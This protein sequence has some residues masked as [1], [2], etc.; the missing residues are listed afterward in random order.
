VDQP[1]KTLNITS[2][3][4]DKGSLN[5]KHFLITCSLA[6][7]QTDLPIVNTKALLNSSADASFINLSIAHLFPLVL[8][9]QPRRVRLASSKLHDTSI[10]HVARVHLSIGHY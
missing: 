10:T 5:S 4:I 7:N 3:G 6:A 8:L 9:K 1:L 2:I